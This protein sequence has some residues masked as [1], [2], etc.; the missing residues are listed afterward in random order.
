MITANSFMKR[1]FGKKLIEEFFPKVDLTTSST[2]RGPTSPATARRRS[3]CSAATASRSGER[4]GPCWASRRAQHAGRP[5]QGYGLAVD[6]GHIDNGQVAE[7]VRHR[8]RP[9]RERTFSKHPWSIGG[10][11][12]ADSR[13]LIERSSTASHSE[14]S[15]R[16]ASKLHYAERTKHTVDLIGVLTRDD[17]DTGT[18]RLPLVDR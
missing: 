12:A 11:G 14:Q 18:L 10:G 3:S 1:E 4:C 6:R 15:K 17:I 8:D 16:L 9:H 5:C 2:P 13:K 7:R